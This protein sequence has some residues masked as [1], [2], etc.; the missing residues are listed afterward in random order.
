MIL[1]WLLSIWCAFVAS[2]LVKLW[3]NCLQTGVFRG[4]RGYKIK[5]D[6]QPYLFWTCMAMMVFF[7]L[8]AY[9]IAAVFLREALF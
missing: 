1:F 5:R 8:L 2:G 7:I 3:L 6:E 4:Q 9:G